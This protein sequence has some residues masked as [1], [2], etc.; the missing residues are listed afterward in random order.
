MC[1]TRSLH[2]VRL[3]SYASTTRTL[4]RVLIRS[5][6]RKILAMSGSVC[7]CDARPWTRFS[8]GGRDA[9][10]PS[11]SSRGQF[12]ARCSSLRAG[13]SELR[14]P[15]AQERNEC[16]LASLSARTGERHA[17]PSWLGQ[18]PRKS[19]VDRGRCISATPPRWLDP[20]VTRM[21]PSSPSATTNSP[22]SFRAMDR[23]PASP[24]Q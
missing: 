12:L 13:S 15:T 23:R 19:T 14:L 4:S 16:G 3:R 8:Y 9:N 2:V 6:R 24:C 20:K 11:M 21:A 22:M 17:S 18:Q 10:R 7:R 5:T 1:S